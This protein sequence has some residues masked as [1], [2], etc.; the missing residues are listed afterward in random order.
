M[1]QVNLLTQN[2]DRSVVGHRGASAYLPEHSLECYAMA[3]AQ[4]ADYIE[5]DVVMTKD[6]VLICLHDLWLETTTDVATRFPERKRANAHYYAAD[7]TLAEIKS[8][9]VFGRLPEAERAAMQGYQVATLE[10]LILLVQRLNRTTGRKVGIF[11]E[12]K[13]PEFHVK[14]GKPL[15]KPLMDLLARYNLGKPESGI[16]I[17]SFDK[18]HLKRLRTDFKTELPL[19]WLVGVLPGL[20]EVDELA[21]WANGLNP[22]RGALVADGKLSEK[23]AE[24]LKRIKAKGLKMFVWTFNADTDQMQTFLYE[25][26]VDGVITNNP[27]FGARAIRRTGQ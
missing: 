7:F 25:Y 5:P 24:V 11:I 1:A 21:T 9:R 3:H 23:G 22:S 12:T 17:Q 8:L 4:G 15:E 18:P 16:V 26:G 13:D 10:E 6:D 2:G 20:D 14:E 27:D 19:M